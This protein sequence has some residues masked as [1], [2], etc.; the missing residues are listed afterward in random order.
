MHHKS[1]SSSYSSLDVINGRS[2]LSPPLQ[3][4]ELLQLAG[5]YSA[6]ERQERIEKYR[7]KRKHRNFGNRITYACRKRLAQGRAR[8]KGRFVTNSSGNDALAH[9]PPIN[10]AYAAIQSIVPEW[11]PEMQASLAGDETCGGASVNLH[12][13]DANE[14]EQLATYIGVSSIDLY[15]YLHCS[16]PPS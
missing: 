1:R 15:T 16:S 8:V 11:W 14:M 4:R 6:E 12:M 5:R 9:E 10:G 3:E 13:C 2:I 7:S